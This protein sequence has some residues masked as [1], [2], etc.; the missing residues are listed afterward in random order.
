M[1]QLLIVWP[2]VHPSRYCR[3]CPLIS[4]LE[5]SWCDFKGDKI[6]FWKE[7]RSNYSCQ[8]IKTRAEILPD[9]MITLLSVTNKAVISTLSQTL[10]TCELNKDQRDLIWWLW[11]NCFHSRWCF[12]FSLSE[13][14]NIHKRQDWWVS[15]WEDCSKFFICSTV[16][17]QC[18]SC[19][20]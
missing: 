11:Y 12:L 14:L 17:V 20:L 16:G 19:V 5:G 15:W 9:C 4:K 13:I 8:I 18:N 7:E 3:Y 2:F 10:M 6:L 1:L